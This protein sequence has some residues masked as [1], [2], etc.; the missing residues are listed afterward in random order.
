MSPVGSY[1]PPTAPHPVRRQ[2]PAPRGVLSVYP[3]S[4]LSFGWK[5]IT[6]ELLQCS[7]SHSHS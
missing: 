5:S 4:H 3:E 6:Q 2:G 7:L 1:T